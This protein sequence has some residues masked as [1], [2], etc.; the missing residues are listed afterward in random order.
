[1]VAGFP[2]RNSACRIRMDSNALS[3]PHS[4]CLCFTVPILLREPLV[5]PVTRPAGFRNV[6]SAVI[7]ISVAH[8]KHG[9]VLIHTSST[10]RRVVADW[11]GLRTTYNRPTLLPSANFAF[12]FASGN[13]PAVPWTNNISPPAQRHLPEHAHG[14]APRTR[15]LHPLHLPPAWTYYRKT[16][17]QLTRQTWRSG[18]RRETKGRRTC[19]RSR[20]WA[21]LIA[22]GSSLCGLAVLVMTTT[23]CLTDGTDRRWTSASNL[24]WNI[25]SSGGQQVWRCDAIVYLLV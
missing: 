22:A 21:C 15:H 5:L 6:S 18:G 4:L 8:T 2:S 13:S 16:T 9:H 24:A 3:I 20:A 23:S 17:W 19:I 12:L 7:L 14:T 11:T 1:M 10:Y 25:S